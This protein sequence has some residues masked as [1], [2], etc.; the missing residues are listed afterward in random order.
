[1]Y[2]LILL[3]QVQGREMCHCML[4]WCCEISKFCVSPLFLKLLCDFQGYYF[5][6]SLLDPGLP[7]LW[8]IAACFLK[9][10]LHHSVLMMLLQAAVSGVLVASDLA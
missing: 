7:I 4:C 1:M 9:N 5:I 6:A 3:L 2:I 10:R 8:R